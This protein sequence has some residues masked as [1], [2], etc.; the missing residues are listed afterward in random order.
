PGMDLASIHLETVKM[1]ESLNKFFTIVIVLFLLLGFQNCSQSNLSGGAGSAGVS[2]FSPPSEKNG[3]A[4]TNVSYIEI[5]NAEPTTATALSQKM[6]SSSSQ[7]LM[8]SPQTGK[9]QLVDDAD[10]VLA[11]RCLS[12]ADLNELN[13]ILSSSSVCSAPAAPSSEI[14]GMSYKPAYASL[15]ADNTSFDLGEEK[16]SCGT[17]KKDLCGDLASVFQN[18][19]AYVKAHFQEMACK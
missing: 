18:Y 6:D 19:V 16:D 12:S 8:V 1:G 13:T 2:S 14:C 17:G 11:E 4:V 5:P 7:R 10:S 3:V 9:I 15:V